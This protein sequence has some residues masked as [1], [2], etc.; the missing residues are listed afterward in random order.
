MRVLRVSVFEKKH[1]PDR[2]DRTQCISQTCNV[3]IAAAAA[4]SCL[5]AWGNQFSVRYL[6]NDIMCDGVKILMWFPIFS[7]SFF[8]SLLQSRVRCLCWRLF[9]IVL[10]F[11]A[12]KLILLRVAHDDDDNDDDKQTHSHF[13]HVAAGPRRIDACR[14]RPSTN[15]YGPENEMHFVDTPSRTHNWE[16]CERRTKLNS[17]HQRRADLMHDYNAQKPRNEMHPAT[18]RPMECTSIGIQLRNMPFRIGS[19]VSRQ[20]PMF[21]DHH[22]HHP[23]PSI[24]E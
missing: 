11:I 20:P 9:I 19:S 24:Y 7:C 17:V 1:V 18:G 15:S 10:V 3:F 14:R 21:M 16:F 5:L 4:P 13:P 6:A 12:W 8:A 2:V 22:Q 23:H